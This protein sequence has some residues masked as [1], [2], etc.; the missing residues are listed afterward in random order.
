MESNL[1]QLL[2]ELRRNDEKVNEELSKGITKLDKLNS[3]N[4]KQKEEPR[5]EIKI[6]SSFQPPSHSLD[7]D[8]FNNQIDEIL[9]ENFKN[10]EIKDTVP[11]LLPNNNISKD[12]SRISDDVSFHLFPENRTQHKKEVN[13]LD[14]TFSLFNSKNDFYKNR[15]K[16]TN[17]KS[18]I[19]KKP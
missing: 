14:N 2:N 12:K 11:D 13:T 19:I 3:V 17:L 18:G 15:E 7:C 8:F 10:E 9:K 4:V 5:K 16:N 6:T 1:E